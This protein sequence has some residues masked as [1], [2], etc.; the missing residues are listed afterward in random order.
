[1]TLAARL[2]AVIGRNGSIIRKVSGFKAPFKKVK[3]LTATI[4]LGACVNYNA[5]DSN[6]VKLAVKGE[7]VMGVIVGTAD[8]VIDLTKDSDNPYAI[9][10]FLWMYVPGEGDEIYLTGKTNVAIAFNDRIQVDGGYCIKFAYVD[11][12]EATDTHAGKIA[13]CQ[14]AITAAGATEKITLA[15]WGGN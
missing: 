9:N 8:G 12:T 13:I 5:E 11:S 2:E 7:P 6:V 15:I 10:T 1:M 4:F 14:K 3:A